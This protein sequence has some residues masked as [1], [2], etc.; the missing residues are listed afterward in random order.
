MS[1]PIEIKKE[2]YDYYTNRAGEKIV[3]VCYILTEGGVVG[4]GVSAWNGKD[5]YDEIIGQNYA[6]QYALRAIKQRSLDP[7]KT[8]E[9]INRLIECKCPFAKKGERNPELSWWERRFLFGTKY[10]HTYLNGIGFCPSMTV[11]E[12]DA[13]V[14]IKFRFGIQRLFTAK[15]RQIWVD[16]CLH[17]AI[18]IN[19]CDVV[20]STG[21]MNY[22]TAPL[23][24]R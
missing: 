10:I 7:I 13:A 8:S 14:R 1:K 4:R 24:K 15:A 2:K 11:V 20:S 16:K 18:T 3:T 22:G 19:A 17:P 6:Q 21:I 9:V 23:I 5:E 12:L